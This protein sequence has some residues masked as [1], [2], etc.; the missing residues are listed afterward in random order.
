MHANG[1]GAIEPLLRALLGARYPPPKSTSI[2]AVIGVNF[3]T[4]QLVIYPRPG[5]SVP[6][7]SDA[8]YP[9]R[10][11]IFERSF[12]SFPFPLFAD[13]IFLLELFFSF[14]FAFKFGY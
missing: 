9:Y 2:L 8:Y 6:L 7:P 10:A 5:L 13:E 4:S 12:P 14:R 3:K 11:S 1:K